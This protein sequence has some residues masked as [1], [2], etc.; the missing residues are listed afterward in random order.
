MEGNTRYHGN[1]HESRQAAISASKLGK[2]SRHDGFNWPQGFWRFSTT[3]LPP[4]KPS[5]SVELATP[6][7]CLESLESLQSATHFPVP[8]NHTVWEGLWGPEVWP[9]AERFYRVLVGGGLMLSMACVDAHIGYA[10]EYW[11]VGLVFMEVIIGGENMIHE[12]SYDS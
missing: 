10:L 8:Q 2:N 11:A 6:V 5:G 12:L 9:K 4:P 3:P 7:L 1:E